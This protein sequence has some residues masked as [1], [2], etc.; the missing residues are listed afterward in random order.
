MAQNHDT[1]GHS[2]S[3]TFGD[4][5][6]AAFMGLIIGAIALLLV[7]RLIVWVTNNHYAGKEH[8]TVETTK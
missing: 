6:K 5:T 4:D 1:H 2:E 8:T 3:H 7:V